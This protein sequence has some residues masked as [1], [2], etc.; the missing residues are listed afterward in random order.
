MRN[1]RE[2]FVIVMI[3]QTA[4]ALYMEVDI[5]RAVFLLCLL[6]F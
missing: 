1:A 5:R 4:D 2:S 6:C 3:K